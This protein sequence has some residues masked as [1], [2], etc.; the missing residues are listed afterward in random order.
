MLCIDRKVREQG[1][2]VRSQ[3]WMAGGMVPRQECLRGHDV[4]PRQRTMSKDV[5]QM[6]MTATDVVQ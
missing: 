2:T 1:P 6:F 4:R 5:R 3:P